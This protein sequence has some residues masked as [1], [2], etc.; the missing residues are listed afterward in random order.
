M[1]CAACHKLILQA[2]ED[3]RGAN[4]FI[5]PATWIQFYPQ[6]SNRGPVPHDVPKDNADDYNEASLVLPVSAK[7][8]TTLARRCLQTILRE[9]GYPQYDLSKQIDAVLAETDTK[10][11]LPTGIYTIVDAIRQFGNFAAH[12]IT[13][14][15]TLEVIDVEPHEADYCLDILDALFDH[16]YVRPATAARMKLLLNAKLQAAQKPPVK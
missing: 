5:D 6:G 3:F 8:S 4:E 10:K 11:A 15:T 14:K 1:S 12:R 13:D 2:G 16:Y 7:A 9:A